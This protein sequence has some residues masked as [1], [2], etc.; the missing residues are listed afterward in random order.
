MNNAKFVLKEEIRSRCKVIQLDEKSIKRF[1]PISME[2]YPYLNQADTVDFSLYFRVES[3]MVEFMKPQEFSEKMLDALWRA[4]L[5]KNADVEICVL[6][7][8]FPKFEYII[9]KIRDKK[10]K[11]VIDKDPTLDPKVLEVY[12]SLS[13]ASQMIVRG[14]INMSV[15]TR[16]TAAAANL[17]QSQL[18][19]QIA[20]G[21]ISRM[22]N[23]DSTL[24]DH[25]A[26]V[27]MFSAIIASTVSRYKLS[28]RDCQ[29]V[30]Q[31][32]LYHDT[33]KS[34]VPNN[35][36]NKPGKFTPEEYEIM[37]SHTHHGHR[38]LLEAIKKGAPI[39]ELA[40]RVAIEHHERFN[41][42]GYPNRKK[43]RYEEDHE[44]GIH[45]YSRI[46]SIADVYSALLMKRVYKEAM[47]ATEAIEIMKGCAEKDFDPTIFE[48]FYQSIME[49]SK[50]FR[51]RER[52]AKRQNKIIMIGEE[53]SFAKAIIERDQL[54]KK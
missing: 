49:S 53:D 23:C 16:A 15:A 4:A 37:K 46:V 2:L 43:G 45:L 18:D 17:M 47:T 10:L 32:G 44:N 11:S 34:C 8:D 26:S 3:E 20:V 28:Q 6:R 50:I 40:A 27:A 24:Y 25:S 51:N 1:M 13:G 30:T 52:E 19:N 54:N 12:S 14:G 39:D 29:I 31:C 36:L 41:G 35:I 7:T 48:P 33:G 38:E 5:M 9:N 21:T 22:I 42:S